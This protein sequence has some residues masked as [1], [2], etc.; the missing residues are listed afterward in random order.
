LA[1]LAWSLNSALLSVTGQPDAL[2][3]LFLFYGFVSGLLNNSVS[4]TE[5]GEPVV[6][7]R[8]LSWYFC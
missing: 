3:V 2:H 6:V 5:V 1:D 4:T 7:Y 8:D